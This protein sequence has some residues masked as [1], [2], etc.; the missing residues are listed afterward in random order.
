MANIFHMAGQFGWRKQVA[1]YNARFNFKSGLILK[2]FLQKCGLQLSFIKV[3][4][5]F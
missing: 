3:G 2:K 5:Y 1:L 4:E